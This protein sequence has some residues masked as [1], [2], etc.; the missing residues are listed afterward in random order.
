MES[1]Y[2]T[3]TP[4]PPHVATHAAPKVTNSLVAIMSAYP[5]S[6]QMHIAANH[7][8]AVNLVS[9]AATASVST[10]KATTTTVQAAA[11]HVEKTKAVAMVDV[12]T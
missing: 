12:S 8:P 7:V 3:A 2:K 9:L 10:P 6:P 5:S 4:V 11:K 1:V